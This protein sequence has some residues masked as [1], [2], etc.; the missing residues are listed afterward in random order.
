[1]YYCISFSLTSDLTGVRMLFCHVCCVRAVPLS[2]LLE[3]SV[4]GLA[5]NAWLTFW[6]IGALM[7]FDDH[8]NL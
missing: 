4:L 6:Q 7:L 5:G 3:L 1:M 2:G 8:Y